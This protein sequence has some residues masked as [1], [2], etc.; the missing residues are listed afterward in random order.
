MIETRPT[1]VDADDTRVSFVHRASSR[2]I[3]IPLALLAA[4][5]WYLVL[6]A[7]SVTLLALSASIPLLLLGALFSVGWQFAFGAFGL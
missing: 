7:F 3:A 2:L 6:F 4:V 5:A 1:S